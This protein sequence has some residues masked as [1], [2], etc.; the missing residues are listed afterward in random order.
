M[1]A[2]F[3]SLVG[4]V[5][6]LGL[7]IYLKVPGMV[8]KNLDE[9]GEKVRDELEEARKLREEAQALLAEYQRKRK[10]AEAEAEGIVAAAKREADAFTKEATRKTEDFVKRRTALAEQKI[11]QAEASALAEVKASAVDVAMSAAEQII[12]GK[13]TGK[14]AD[15]LIKD[16][17]K[18]IKAKLN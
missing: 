13:M 8:A 2:T 4:L 6:F 17:I 1:D 12:A 5:I 18:E 16:S 9:R 11:E 10:D 7:V 15:A 14:P 3:F